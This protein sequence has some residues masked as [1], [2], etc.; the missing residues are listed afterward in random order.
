[1]LGQNR[2][3]V[4]IDYTPIA[5][6]TPAGAPAERARSTTRPTRAAW[7]GGDAA[8]LNLVRLAMAVKQRWL[9]GG[10][11]QHLEELLVGLRPA[12]LVDEGLGGGGGIHAGTTRRRGHHLLEHAAHQPYP[13]EH[14]R[15]EQQ[16]LAARAGAIEV[17]GRE[18]AAPVQLARQM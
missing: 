7:R 13:L 9:P 15:A 12:K 6:G 10:R 14:G 16:F 1:M 5:R 8:P 11:R 17:E 2:T 3:F 18:D 4:P